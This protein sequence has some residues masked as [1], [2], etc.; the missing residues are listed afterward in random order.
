LKTVAKRFAFTVRLPGFVNG[1]RS[2]LRKS[3]VVGFAACVM[4][5]LSAVAS[6]NR[7]LSR[8]EG[9]RRHFAACCEFVVQLRCTLWGNPVEKRTLQWLKDGAPKN[10]HFLLCSV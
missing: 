6:D 10:K 1:L 9:A 7:I 3:L 8:D 4:F 2:V 5:I